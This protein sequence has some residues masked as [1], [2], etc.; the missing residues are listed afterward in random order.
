MDSQKLVCS[1][2]KK[3]TDESDDFC[4]FCGM[5]FI[6]NVTCYNH[7]NKYA[8]GACV[9]CNYAFCSDCGM[10]INYHFLCNEHSDYETYESL[11]VIGESEDS[12]DIDETKNVLIES[13]LHPFV[14]HL[15]SGKIHPAALDL[16]LLNKSNEFYPGD[17]LKLLVPFQ[18][19]MKSEEILNNYQNEIKGKHNESN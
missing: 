1:N 11:A 8:G 16:R 18:E 19:V 10:T 5:L 9:I 13:G 17:K 15:Q 14:Y 6:E 4:S 3:E 12:V 7:E 2:C